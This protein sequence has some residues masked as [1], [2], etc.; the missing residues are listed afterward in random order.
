MGEGAYSFAA[1]LSHLTID[2]ASFSRRSM[3]MVWRGRSSGC[4]LDYFLQVVFGLGVELLLIHYSNV[5]K[6]IDTMTQAKY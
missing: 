2:H 4:E 3:S 6:S 5:R 1:C